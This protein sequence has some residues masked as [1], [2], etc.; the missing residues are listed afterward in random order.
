MSNEINAEINAEINTEINMISLLEGTL[1][2]ISEQAKEN[3]HIVNTKPDTKLDTNIVN[4]NTNKKI[5]IDFTKKHFTKQEKELIRKE[6]FIVTEKYPNY[7][8]I[9][10]TPKSDEIKLLRHKFLVGGD[11][12]VGQ[13]VSIIR[14]KIKNFKSSESIFLLIN[15]TL[16]PSTKLLSSVYH[17][18]SD[19]ETNMLYIVLCKENTFG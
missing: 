17:E 19:P 16:V 10:V 6:V 11:I 13:F 3:L 4:K 15:N 5:V 14:K 1:E 7:I 12:T 9:V 18:P 2:H 8:P